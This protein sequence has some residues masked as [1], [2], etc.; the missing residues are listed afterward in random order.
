[1]CL[2]LSVLMSQELEH[3]IVT[4]FGKIEGLAKCRA[5]LTQS[6]GLKCKVLKNFL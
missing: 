3:A 4:A 6:L 2:D 5:N 1:M